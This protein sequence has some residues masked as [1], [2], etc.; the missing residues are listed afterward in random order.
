MKQLGIL[1]IDMQDYF[2]NQNLPKE[3]EQL[4]SA[5]KRLLNF[6]SENQI[7][8]FALEYQSVKE[9]YGITSKEL[10]EEL[11]RN[12]VYF[13]SKYEDNGFLSRDSIIM[14]DISGKD[15]QNL[16]LIKALQREQIKNLILTGINKDACVLKTAE[17]AKERKYEIFTS[18]EL[19]N[20]RKMEVE[21]FSR[22]SN[23]HQ[24]LNELLGN[25]NNS[26]N[27]NL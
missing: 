8:I 3:I 22:Y 1:L 19:M 13:I 25:L 21:W 11:Q 16:E 14:G 15:H 6:A 18:E 23:H 17:G 2:I 5:Q 7:P 10:K 12:K 24:T 4:I 9:K 20:R 26:I 27:P